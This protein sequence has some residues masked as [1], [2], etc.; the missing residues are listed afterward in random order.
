MTNADLLDLTI[1]KITHGNIYNIDPRSAYKINKELGTE[2]IIVGKYKISGSNVSLSYQIINLFTGSKIHGGSIQKELYYILEMINEMAQ[3]Y[4]T[5]TQIPMSAKDTDK[6]NE[7]ITSHPKAFQYYCK[8]YVEFQKPAAN[9]S[10]V[11][12]LFILAISKDPDFWEARYNLGSTLYNSKKY[13]SA[14]NQF[15]NV[16]NRQPKFFKAYF[17]RGLIYLKFRQYKNALREFQSVKEQDKDNKEVDY[18]LG[19]LYNRTDK[20]LDA[21]NSLQIAI[22]KNPE[23]APAYYELGLAYFNRSDVN[24]TIR[25]LKEA[26]RIKPSYALAHHEIGVAYNSIKQYDN[27]IFHFEKAI[28]YFPNYANAYFDLGNTYYKQGVLQEFIENYLDIINTAKD[29]TTKITKAAK[30][31]PNMKKTFDLIIK[32]L[33]QSIRIDDE[34]YEAHFNIALTYHKYG[35]YSEARQHYER[36]LELNPT[37]IKAHMQ[38]GYLLEEQGQYPMAMD[39]FKKVVRIRPDYF[40]PKMNLGEHFQYRNPI[41]VVQ[42]EAAA[43]LKKNPNDLDSRLVLAK[44]YDVLGQR[45]KALD[46]YEEVVKLNPA[47]RHS[48]KRV[49]EL[50]EKLQ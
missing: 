31:S 14:L 5:I 42:K 38:L 44:I 19:M 10:K 16:L 41:N 6:L 32:A 25:Y 45:Q 46:E 29:A 7:K 33:N 28:G 43:R 27:A 26:I 17:G 21:I 23:L 35:K 36:T 37:L 49:R 39:E 30:L 34:F 50:R 22:R 40:D 1:Y 4:A 24:K 3:D 11:A 47:D 20:R 13:K 48:I 18:Y 15:D 12:D 2:I 8:A 9:N